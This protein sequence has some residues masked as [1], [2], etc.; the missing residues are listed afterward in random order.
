MGGDRRGLR[1][2]VE[3]CSAEHLVAAAG[4]GF[5]GSGDDPEQHIPQWIAAPDLARAVQ[6][7][8]A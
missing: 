6:E 2:D 7:E 3:V 5:L 4:N 8:P 1:N